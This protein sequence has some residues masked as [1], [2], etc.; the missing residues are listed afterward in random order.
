MIGSDCGYGI[1]EGVNIGA[2]TGGTVVDY[3][4]SPILIENDRVSLHYS[5]QYSC[6]KGVLSIGGRVM[7]SA[8]SLRLP[9]V[10]EC[11]NIHFLLNALY[12]AE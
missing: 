7:D 4:A 2:F 9:S 5:Y 6:E 12:F 1:Q 8:Q 11:T 3:Q 10:C